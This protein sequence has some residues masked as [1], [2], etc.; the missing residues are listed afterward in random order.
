MFCWKKLVFNFLCVTG[1]PRD[2]M[3]GPVHP[4]MPG[5]I[6]RGGPGQRRGMARGGQLEVAGVVVSSWVPNFGGPRGR[7]HSHLGGSV[8]GRGMIPPQHVGPQRNGPVFYPVRGGR[9]GRGRKG[10]SQ[11][12]KKSGGNSCPTGSAASQK[13][14][15]DQTNEKENEE[16]TK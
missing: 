12:H 14:A 16:T 6:K 4:H 2:F 10:G 8:M 15:K 11:S 1:G 3:P 9:S 5:G 7:G 13:A